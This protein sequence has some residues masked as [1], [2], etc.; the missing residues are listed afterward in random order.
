MIT[1]EMIVVRTF[2]PIEV[3]V[4]MPDDLKAFEK[5]YIEATLT[6]IKQIAE[7]VPKE[8]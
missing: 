7:T 4:H 6:A 8:A 2:K 1:R 5:I 3:V